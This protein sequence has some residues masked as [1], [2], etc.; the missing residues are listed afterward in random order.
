MY[1]KK[2]IIEEIKRTTKENGGKPL[3]EKSFR[4]ET[5]IKSWD[6]MGVYWTKWGDAV[7]EAGFKRNKPWK[8]HREGV[9]EK[10]AIYLIRKLGRYFTKAEIRLEKNTSNP[11][12]HYAAIDKRRKKDFISSLIKY[13]EKHSGYEDIL[14]ICRPILKQLN[15]KE[16]SG[17]LKDNIS[18][19]EV[20]LYK[21]GGH[22]KIGKSKDT[23]RRGQEIKLQSPEDPIL[24]HTIKTDDVVG[25]ERYWHNRFKDKRMKGEWF[26]LKPE[27]IKAFKGWKK[28][29]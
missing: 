28:I 7:E 12:F 14:K 25:I 2:E 10:D 27:D 16:N 22:Y 13:C 26:K 4:N 15:G 5:N 1:S 8:K 21:T 3:G 11:K 18:V 6:W 20:Y 24:I 17:S 9:V 19:G 23:V 29:Y